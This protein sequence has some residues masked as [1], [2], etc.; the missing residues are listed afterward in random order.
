LSE[1]DLIKKEPSHKTPENRNQP[2]SNYSCS[3]H[4]PSSMDTELFCDEALGPTASVNN[5][6]FDGEAEV[7]K[8]VPI[9]ELTEEEEIISPAFKDL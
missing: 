8:I 6:S 1:E 4:Y 9:I 2:R 5:F 7:G 3:P